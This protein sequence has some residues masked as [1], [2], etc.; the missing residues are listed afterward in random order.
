MLVQ[1]TEAGL[2]LRGLMRMISLISLKLKDEVH[3]EA[4][5]KRAIEAREHILLLLKD[6]DVVEIDLQDINFTPS[7][8]DEVIGGLAEE[9]GPKIFKNKIKLVNVSESQLALMKHVIARRLQGN[10]TRQ[11]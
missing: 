7:I 4:S 1:F 6:K 2:N 10:K 9:L 3:G 8:A 11:Y 5:R